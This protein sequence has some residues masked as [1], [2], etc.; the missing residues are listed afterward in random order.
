M[1]ISFIKMKIYLCEECDKE[2]KRKMKYIR[3]MVYKHGHERMAFF[4]LSEEESKENE[5]KWILCVVGVTEDF[6]QC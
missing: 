2:F 6:L 4:H 3:H 1:F 5:V